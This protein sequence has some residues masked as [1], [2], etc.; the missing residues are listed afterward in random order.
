MSKLQT[1]STGDL[2][3]WLQRDGSFQFWNVLTD[4]YFNGGM[5]P[6]SRRVPLYR[7]GREVLTAQIPKDAEIVVYWAGP[8][9]PQSMLA[10][11]KLN[12]LGHT[13]VKAY[14]GGIEEWKSAGNQVEQLKAA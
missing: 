5:I 6:G 9:F 11:E 2:Q 12:N 1:I 4:K 7:V 13:N 10:A 14:E 8:S 3:R